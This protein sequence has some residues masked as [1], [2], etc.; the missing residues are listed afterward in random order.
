[1]SRRERVKPVSSF[2]IYFEGN[3]LAGRGWEIQEGLAV[4]PLLV[5]GGLK[6]HDLKK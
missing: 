2:V 6:V 5:G 3:N 4:E 1:M